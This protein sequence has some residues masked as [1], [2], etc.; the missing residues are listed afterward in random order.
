MFTTL[1]GA[2][3]LSGEKTL[4]NKGKYID[5]L[6]LVCS[7]NIYMILNFYLFIFFAW[8]LG[9]ESKGK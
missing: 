9:V 3:C 2:W 8:Y 7:L 6:I 1:L 5:F 4:E